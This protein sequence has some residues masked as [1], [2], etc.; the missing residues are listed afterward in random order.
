M[1]Y[2]RQLLPQDPAFFR[3]Q[4]TPSIYLQNIALSAMDYDDSE[5]QQ[6]LLIPFDIGLT[7][8]A[9]VSDDP[10]SQEQVFQAAVFNADLDEDEED[11]FNAQPKHTRK[12]EYYKGMYDR[13][14]RTRAVTSL[15]QRAEIKFR[16]S[17]FVTPASNPNLAWMPHAHY[18]DL[19]I[20]VGDGLGLGALIPNLQVHQNYEMTIDLS[21]PYRTFSTKFAK[22]GF[23]PT[24]C[25]QFIG[26]SPASEDV[27]LAWTPRIYTND[28]TIV[29]S[30]KSTAMS[31]RR[32]R[33]SFMFLVTMLQEIGARDVLVLT[34]YPK[35]DD[36]DEFRN[37]TRIP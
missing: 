23:D 31:T 15:D 16:N 5:T 13:Q 36:D 1:T 30:K 32:S 11:S 20:F 7:P 33:L 26:R 24:G 27:W 17:P 8:D 10:A 28:E 14:D 25:I 9:L 34:K 22:L 37:A 6:D 12:L 2:S 35:V 3:E 18:L 21:Q 29:E 4:L 19:M